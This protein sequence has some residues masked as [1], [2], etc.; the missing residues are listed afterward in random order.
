VKRFSVMMRRFVNYAAHC[1][2]GADNDSFFGDQEGDF[3]LT[4]TSIKAV[5]TPE[6]LEKGLSGKAESPPV[7]KRDVRL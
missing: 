2:G 3:S 4:I 5:S 6:D 1:S 7:Q